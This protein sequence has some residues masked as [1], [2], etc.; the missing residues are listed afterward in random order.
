MSAA[1]RLLDAP[2]ITSDLLMDILQCS[3]ANATR[4]IVCLEA[5]GGLCRIAA[6]E[7]ILTPAG[8]AA[9]ERDAAKAAG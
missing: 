3:W 8:R 5:T 4:V 2:L 7:Y 6:A 9:L 1:Q